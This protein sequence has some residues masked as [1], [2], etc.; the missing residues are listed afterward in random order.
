MIEMEGDEESSNSEKYDRSNKKR[1]CRQGPPPKH[2][3]FG[4]SMRIVHEESE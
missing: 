4:E 2:G 1:S 3:S